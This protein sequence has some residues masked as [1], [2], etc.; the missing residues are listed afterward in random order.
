MGRVAQLSVWATQQ[1]IEGAGLSA[2]ELSSGK[3]GLAYGSTTG[4]MPATG[5]FCQALMSDQNIAGLQ[6]VTYLKLMSHTAPANVA[7]YFQIRGRVLTTCSAC[8]S[9]SQAIVYGYEAVKYGLQEVM[10]C[11]GA[12]EINIANAAVFEVMFATSRRYNESPE[13]TPR[14]FDV[15]R[16]GLVVG[17]GAGTLVLESY[18]RAKARG[19]KIYAEIIGAVTNC[20]GWH[21]TAPS[22][23]GMARVIQGALQEAKINAEQL[24]YINAHAIATEI[25]DRIESRAVHR[26]VGET[27]PISSTKGFTGHTLGACG[28]LE[29]V[30]CLAMMQ[31]QFLASTRNLETLDPLCAPLNYLIGSAREANPCVVMSNNFAFA[32]LN[33]SIVLR[34]I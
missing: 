12:E 15:A 9:S 28:S 1:A 23:E 2:E 5:E 34:K 11:G 31:N 8:V 21:L 27:V 30:F 26:V 24:D 14:P 4:S 25:G 29:V 7:A 17:E 18:S 3:I 32:G 6:S 13:K 22:E 16:D 10:I 33:T 19:A 20:D